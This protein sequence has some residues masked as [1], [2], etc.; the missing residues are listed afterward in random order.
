MYFL[1]R[2]VRWVLNSTLTRRNNFFSD[3]STCFIDLIYSIFAVPLFEL[4][5]QIS[6]D[7]KDKLRVGFQGAILLSHSNRYIFKHARSGHVSSNK[8]HANIMLIE[9]HSHGFHMMPAPIWL[10]D[11]FIF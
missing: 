2:L 8:T 1:F 4:L 3:S 9:L 11:L 10:Q 7:M 6:R 5:W